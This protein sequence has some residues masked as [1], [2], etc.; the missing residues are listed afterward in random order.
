M[1]ESKNI[2]IIDKYADTVYKSQSIVEPAHETI[3]FL[4]EGLFLVIFKMTNGTNVSLSTCK[5]K[6]HTYLS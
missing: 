4:G 3:F 1:T 5:I 2:Q 6:Q